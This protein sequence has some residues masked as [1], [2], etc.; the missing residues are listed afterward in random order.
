VN[1]CKFLAA[2]SDEELEI[3]AMANP[4]LSAAKK[5]LDELS[6]GRAGGLSEGLAKGQTGL[7]LRMLGA[8]FGPVP[9]DVE[10]QIRSASA[11]DI[12]GYADRLLTVA[13]LRDVLE[14]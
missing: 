13:T 10:A 3:L 14:A 11:A 5:A 12:A 6:E 4:D 7:L 8:R 1:W 9:A 2:Q